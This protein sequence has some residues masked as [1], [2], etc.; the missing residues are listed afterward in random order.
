[1][2]RIR[3]PFVHARTALVCDGELRVA[4]D[5]RRAPQCVAVAARATLAR[6]GKGEEGGRLGLAAAARRRGGTVGAP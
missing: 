4:L 5:A 3:S 6:E 2:L 1:M